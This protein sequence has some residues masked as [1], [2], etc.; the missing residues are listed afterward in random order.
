MPTKLDDRISALVLAF[1]CLARVL[2]YTQLC[3]MIRT[4]MKDE[5]P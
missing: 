4:H 5:R 2:Q 1:L 3:D